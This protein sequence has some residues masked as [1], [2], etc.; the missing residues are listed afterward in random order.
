MAFSATESPF[1]QQMINDIPN[2]SMPFTSRWTLTARISREFELDRQ[3]LIQ[4]LAISSQTIALSLDGWTSRN[5]ISILVVIGHW[6]TEDFEYQERVL[7]FVEIEGI[8]SGENMAGLIISLMQELDIGCKVLSIT[9]DN[10][11]NNEALIDIIESSLQ[12]QFPS[13]S[14]SNTPRF[15]S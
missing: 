8:K 9:G 7:E 14:I 3:Q 5:D 1:F 13:T 15:H 6:L 12:E 4:D 10:A 2:I 11:S